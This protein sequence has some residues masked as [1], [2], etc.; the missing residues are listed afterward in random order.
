MTWDEPMERWNDLADE[1]DGI[2]EYYSEMTGKNIRVG[3]QS[4]DEFFI[5]APR[6][7]GREYLSSLKDADQRLKQLYE[8]VLPDDGDTTDPYAGL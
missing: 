5:E 2:A 7:N 4:L 6:T 1:A 8:D 3:V